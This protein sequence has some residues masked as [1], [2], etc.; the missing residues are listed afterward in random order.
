[1][2]LLTR[3]QLLALFYLQVSNH[4]GFFGACWDSTAGAQQMA[5]VPSQRMHM[6]S[7]PKSNLYCYKA[8]SCQAE[9]MNVS[10]W[11]QKQLK[12]SYLL[13]LPFLLWPKGHC[14]LIGC[15]GSLE[16]CFHFL[17]LFIVAKR[18]KRTKHW[19]TARWAA[20]SSWLFYNIQERTSRGSWRV[21]NEIWDIPCRQ[22]ILHCL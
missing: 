9:A 7:A 18:I 16:I 12:Y 4:V 21:G 19:G 15:A 8:G 5:W 10:T 6:C 11:C 17:S 2:N 22:G 3:R 14:S 13:S 1:M 20:V